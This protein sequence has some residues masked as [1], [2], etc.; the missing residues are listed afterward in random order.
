M[1]ALLRTVLIPCYWDRGHGNRKRSTMSTAFS[2]IGRSKVETGKVSEVK[3][4]VRD[5]LA[6]D[7]DVMILV[8]ELPCSEP[9]CPPIET[10]I[11]LIGSDLRRVVTIHGTVGELEREVVE[12]SL[13]A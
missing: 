3:G 4:W 12:R 13:G 10:A 11:T 9:G 8:T 7:D 5:A 6:L 2:G 1:V